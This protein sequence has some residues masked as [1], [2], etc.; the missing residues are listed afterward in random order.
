MGDGRQPYVA[1]SRENLQ[2]FWRNPDSFRRS[3]RTRR[4]YPI[5]QR[6]HATCSK[7][8]AR[9]P[10][11]FHEMSQQGVK[12]LV[13]DLRSTLMLLPRRPFRPATRKGPTGRCARLTNPI[14]GCCIQSPSLTA[15]PVLRWLRHVDQTV[16]WAA[17][18]TCRP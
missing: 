16:P 5:G 10:S 11:T 9:H 6:V 7:D 8:S 3:T 1:A 4:E 2:I 14:P 13:K 17:T 15:R 18:R 12:R